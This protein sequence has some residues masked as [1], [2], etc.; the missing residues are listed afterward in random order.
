[1]H[2]SNAIVNLRKQ[3]RILTIAIRSSAQR[4]LSFKELQQEQGVRPRQPVQDIQIRW[5]ST[6]LML[7]RAYQLREFID[8]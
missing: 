3:V 7:R 4:K 8:L 5:N 2:Q 6:Y 1:M